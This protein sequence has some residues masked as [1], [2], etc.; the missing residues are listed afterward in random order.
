MTVH[1][2]Y[3]TV[4]WGLWRDFQT[5]VGAEKMP[6]QPV[7]THNVPRRTLVWLMEISQL[8]KPKS[9]LSGL[10]SLPWETKGE[11]EFFWDHPQDDSLR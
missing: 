8:S 10:P 4:G 5:T 7:Q 1:A 3:F 9:C 2:I 6:L 11:S